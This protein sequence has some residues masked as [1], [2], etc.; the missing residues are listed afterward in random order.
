MKQ[1]VL[2]FAQNNQTDDY[3]KQAYL[4]AMS[5]MKNGNMHFTLVTDK[6]VEEKIAFVF[7][8]VILLKHDQAKNSEWK[9]ENR[10]KAYNLSP[11][12]ETIVVDSD[13][14]FLE[15]I[16]WSKFK[17]QELY[18]TQNPI[19]YRQEP[20]NDTYYRKAF[21]QNYL[22]NIYTGLYYFKKT[23]RVANFFALLETVIENWEDFYEIF[24]KNHKPKHCSIDVCAAIVLE[25]ME[26]DNFQ[27]V[28]IIDFV[29]MKLHAQNW[30]DTSEHWQHK[31][32]W[33]FNDG[34]K[35]GN[36]KQHGVFHY[37][38]KDFCDKILARYEHCT[39]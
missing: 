30:V 31:V 7:D 4:C 37:T 5:G 15:K 6:E 13:V 32:D 29:H 34:L 35:I 11:Y 14:L 23:K 28:D 10:W 2:I 38:E 27:D 16:N 20:I 22:I 12:D 9:I 33:Y 19:T 3:V 39:G 21:S 1:G 8:K 26:Y 25:L 24:C 36:H 17:D 18:F